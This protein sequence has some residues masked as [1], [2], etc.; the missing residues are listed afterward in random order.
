MHNDKAAKFPAITPR[1]IRKIPVGSK[2]VAIRSF[3]SDN[4]GGI[5][6]YQCGRDK[7]TRS[8][9]PRVIECKTIGNNSRIA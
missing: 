5:A 2:P 8:V 3:V 6:G 9:G 1:S 4:D 7:T